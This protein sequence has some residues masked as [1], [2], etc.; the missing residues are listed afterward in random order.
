M[1]FGLAASICSAAVQPRK[2]KHVVIILQENRTVDNVFGSNPNFEPGVD[3]QNF[4]YLSNGQRVSLAS[5]PW[6]TCFDPEHSL[7]AFQNQWDKGKMDGADKNQSL[8]HLGRPGCVLP[9]LLEYSY[10]DNSTGQVEPYFEIAKRY[11][12]ANRMFQTTRGPSYS[13]HQFFLAGTSAPTTYS[14]LFVAENPD[15][16]PQDCTSPPDVRVPVV[17]E[18]GDEDSNPPIYPCFEHP[19]LPDVLNG[20]G[21]TWKYYA[22]TPHG[23]WNAP[24]SIDHLCQAAEK[25]GVKACSGPD[26]VNND[27][28]GSHRALS[29]IKDCKLAQVSWITPTGKES[30]HPVMNDG[31][32]PPWVASV[33]NAL[34]SHPPCPGTGEVYWEDTAIFITWDDWGGWY[35]HVP[36]THNG[37]PNGW[38]RGFTYG[39][40]VPLLVVSAYTPAGFVENEEHDT[41]SILKFIE[42]NFSTGL[43]GPGFYADAYP[44]DT[45][46]NYFTLQSPRPFD[47]IPVKFNYQVFML[48]AEDTGRN[49]F[50]EMARCGIG[51]WF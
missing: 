31:R 29:D 4:G 19:T 5:V 40:R 23:I 48:N 1:I 28:I 15:K 34:G 18:D 16:E 22:D 27:V 30:D 42:A 33:V 45:M 37:Q 12:F 2:F 38:G 9:P 43:I 6:D 3:I 21:V 32:G 25:G 39:F 44:K 36:P 20:A 8:A 24:N 13:A 51:C 46:Q 10:V 11:G 41:G 14:K 26:W 50:T 35:D 47:R 17:D 49:I 7:A